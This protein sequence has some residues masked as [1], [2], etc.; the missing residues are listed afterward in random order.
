MTE[1]TKTTISIRRRIAHM[2]EG[3]GHPD[4][5]EWPEAHPIDLD[6]LQLV[7][8]AL[9]LESEF[10]IDFWDELIPPSPSIGDFVD[11]VEAALRQ[12][13]VNDRKAS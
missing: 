2:L 5:L 7:E 6:S 1:P 11:M 12:K 9:H 10:N 8:L 3:F 4:A 13:S